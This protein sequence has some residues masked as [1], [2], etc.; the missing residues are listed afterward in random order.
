M[1]LMERFLLK[2]WFEHGGICL[3]SVN[4]NAKERFGYAII[5]EE[6][7]ISKV[8]VNELYTLEDEYHSY[9]NWDDPPA[10][11]PWTA[12]QKKD[13]INRATNV[14]HKLLFEL[15]DEFEIINKLD[16]CVV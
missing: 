3:W 9:L 6:L 12:K 15:D 8:L 4:Q 10:A 5:N 14:Y 2:Y 11:S 1:V 13:F 7:P 16:S